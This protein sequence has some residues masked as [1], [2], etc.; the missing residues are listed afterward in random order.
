MIRLFDD[1]FT[2]DHVAAADVSLRIE[3]ADDAIELTATSSGPRRSGLPNSRPGRYF[4]SGTA[5]P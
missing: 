4:E 5:P 1:A 3:G 2:I